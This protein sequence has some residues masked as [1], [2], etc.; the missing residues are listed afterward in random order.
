MH[1]K[2]LDGIPLF[3]GL[4]GDE[5]WDLAR[6]I[7]VR[8]VRAQDTLFWIGE[9]GDAFFVI[10]T[11]SVHITYPDNDGK[12]VILATLGPG[13]FFGEVSLLD[14]GVRTATARAATDVS[15]LTLGRDAFMKFIADHPSA[16]LHIMGVL[17][18]RQRDTVDKLRGIR[19]LNEVMQDRLTTWQRIANA[20]AAM[21]AS[22]TF[23][24]CHAI[25]FGGWI[26][27]NII[28]GKRGPDPFP[29]AF[30]CFWTSTEAIFLS[31]FIMISQSVQGQKDRLRTELEYQVA[32]KAQLDIIQ[33][34]RKVD[35]L[36]AMVLA[37]VRWAER[38]RDVESGGESAESNG[39]SDAMPVPAVADGE[40]ADTGL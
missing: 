28:L 18:K 37:E 13:G 34:H 4:S 12:E 30:L 40:R 39:E 35:E 14:G 27:M 24:L 10:H 6:R 19:N 16:A 7:T 9:R 22:Q 36:P 1:V 20:I 5:K 33:L 15:V 11:G 17:G 2:L 29:F 23:L 31:L 26:V 21:A 3:A 32:L 38:T 25:A 8:D